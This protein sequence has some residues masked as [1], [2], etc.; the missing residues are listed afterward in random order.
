MTEFSE[1]HID[2]IWSNRFF[3]RKCISELS[4]MSPSSCSFIFTI[5]MYL[6]IFF[7]KYS[8]TATAWYWI[9]LHSRIS[10]KH[11]ILFVA[12]I[13]MCIGTCSLLVAVQNKFLAV[14]PLNSFRRL[15]YLHNIFIFFVNIQLAVIKIIHNLYEKN[16]IAL[17][18]TRVEIYCV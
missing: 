10:L 16:R 7:I 2:G 18:A 11:Y 9:Y 14:F 4:F 12:V 17:S 1:E 8:W 15:F 3:W 6:L 13:A 5:S